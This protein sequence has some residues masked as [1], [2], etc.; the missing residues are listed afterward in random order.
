MPAVVVDNLSKTYRVADKAPGLRGAVRHLV[1]RKHRVVE[2]VRGVSFAIEPGEVVGF[3]GANG[4]GKTTVMKMLTGLVHP[5]SGD[6]RVLGHEPRRRRAA[7]LRQITLVMGNKQQLVWD[8]P[9]GDTL[10][11]NAAVYGIP[12]GEA[13]RRTDELCAVLGLG[14]DK[15]LTQ[16]VRKLSLGQ[17]LKCELVAALLHHPKVLFLDEPTLG[18]DVNAQTAVRDFVRRYNAEHGASVLLTSHYM[19]DITALCDRVIVI[20]RGRLHFDG[21]LDDLAARF[22]PERQVRVELAD[23]ADADTLSAYGAVES[24][25]GRVATLRVPRDGVPAAVSRLLSDHRVVDLTVADA[26]IDEVV[27]KLFADAESES[28]SESESESAAAAEASEPT[29]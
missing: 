8:L 1:R 23:P 5:T 19:A 26:P 27:E 6:A 17:R 13:R 14:R 24:V 4:A 29:P 22:A 9:A 16:P 7:L 10:R 3:L 2:A 12:D 18:L 20:H 28:K 25:D 21:R 15:E 11:L